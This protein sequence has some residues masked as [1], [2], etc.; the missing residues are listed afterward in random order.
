MTG[1]RHM[2][3]ILPTKLESLPSTGIFC[4]EQRKCGNSLCSSAARPHQQARGG[5]SRCP[6]VRCRPTRS[7][8]SP[9]HSAQRASPLV[10]VPDSCRLVSYV[11]ICGHFAGTKGAVPSPISIVSQSS[12]GTHILN[13]VKPS[14]VRQMRSLKTRPQ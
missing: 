14:Y 4:V 3:G 9:S 2:P 13:V 7:T 12:V 6:Q 10:L 1:S 5:R 8:P 11:F